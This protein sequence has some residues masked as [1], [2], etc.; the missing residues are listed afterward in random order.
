[1]P[2]ARRASEDRVYDFAGGLSVRVP[3][4]GRQPAFTHAG[5]IGWVPIARKIAA[6]LLRQLRAAIAKNER[7]RQVRISKG[8][9]L[10][11]ELRRS[12]AG[13]VYRLNEIVDGSRVRVERISDGITG[14]VWDAGESYTWAKMTWQSLDLCEG[15]PSDEPKVL[16]EEIPTA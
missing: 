9:V 14:E 6:D 13:H 15:E 16:C 1:M 2:N 8:M 4:D 3:R 11:G 7:E 10:V 12:N 5:L